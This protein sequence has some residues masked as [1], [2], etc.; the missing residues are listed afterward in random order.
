MS[1]V[2]NPLS[3]SVPEPAFETWLRDTGYLE[4]LDERTTA[5][6]STTTTTS[7]TTSSSSPSSSAAGATSSAAVAGITLLSFLRTLVSLVSLNPF[8]KLAADDFAGP[9]PSWTLDFVGRGD[10]YSWPAGPS[11]AR[12]RVQENVRRYARNYAS[13]FVVFFVCSLYR[14]PLSLL[15]LVASLVIWE[16]LRFCS[17]KWELEERW[18]GLRQALVRVA[19]F[20]TAVVLYLCKLQFTLVCAISVSYAVMILHAS[21][22]KLTPS[23]QSNGMNRQRRFQ[24]KRAQFPSK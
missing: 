8:A 20:A 19:Q 23:S 15:G 24:Q 2:P 7:V 10:Y 4:L 12:M 17:E 21:L 16:M 6:A 1:F 5:A 13:L 3:L 22:R 18:P 14:M 9:T 11:Q